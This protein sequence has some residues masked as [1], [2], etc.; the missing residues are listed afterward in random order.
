MTTAEAAQK[1]LDG[2]ASQ[3]VQDAMARALKRRKKGRTAPLSRVQVTTLNEN[4]SAD[5][6]S[7]QI[8]EAAAAALLKALPAG[9]VT[10]YPPSSVAALRSTA[11]P[12]WPGRNQELA[13]LEG[14]ACTISAGG[15]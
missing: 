14:R 15:R 13:S 6:T 9:D 4:G 1:A 12:A 7:W 2:A 10:H 11:E 8:T 3:A 5:L